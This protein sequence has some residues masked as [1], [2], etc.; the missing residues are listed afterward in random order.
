[1]RRKIKQHT[2]IHSSYIDF[3]DSF[4]GPTTNMKG[5]LNYAPL[6][7]NRNQNPSYHFQIQLGIK[8][9]SGQSSPWRQDRFRPQDSL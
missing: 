4:E 6:M 3:E 5:P 2:R 7:T 8:A 9:Q 1:M